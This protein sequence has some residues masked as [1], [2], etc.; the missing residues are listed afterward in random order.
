MIEN[1]CV[2]VVVPLTACST[3]VYV[4]ICVG[5]PLMTPLALIASPGGNEPVLTLTVGA[6]T[7]VVVTGKVNEYGVCHLRRPTAARS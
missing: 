1:D 3:P 7:P 4:P 5:V 2:T 6:G